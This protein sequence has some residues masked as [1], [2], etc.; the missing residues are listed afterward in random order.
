MKFKTDYYLESPPKATPAK[1]V[2]PKSELRERGLASG[3]GGGTSEHG[4]LWRERSRTACPALTTSSPATPNTHTLRYIH[5]CLPL[6]LPLSSFDPPLTQEC[7]QLSHVPPSLLL[8]LY[9]SLSLTTPSPPFLFCLF[10]G[11]LLI[12][13]SAPPPKNI[14]DSEEVRPTLLIAPLP[15]GQERG[16]VGASGG[17][18]QGIPYI[19]HC[20]LWTSCSFLPL[21]ALYSYSLF[22]LPFSNRCLSH[23]SISCSLLLNFPLVLFLLIYFLYSP[24]SSLFFF[25]LPFL[26]LPFPTFGQPPFLS[27]PPFL[28]LPSPTPILDSLLLIPYSL[29]SLPPSPFFSHISL[30]SHS[31]PPR[32]FAPSPPRRSL[33]PPDAPFAPR[34]PFAPPD[35]P[36]TRA[37]Q[38]PPS[39]PRRFSPPRHSPPRRPRSPPRRPLRPQTPPSPPDG[40]QTDCF[41]P[42]QFRNSRLPPSISSPSLSPPSSPTPSLSPPSFT[43]P[44]LS[45]LLSLLLP[46]HYTLFPSFSF[47]FSPPPSIFSPSLTSLLSLFPP[48]SPISPSLPTAQP[49]PPPPPR[50]F[51]N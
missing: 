30:P 4:S 48:L 21:P 5:V 3:G 27:I 14:G 38:T 34:R 13:S 11:V 26:P 49:Y 16:S 8:S 45:P 12:Q 24:S 42:R 43:C 6:T 31:P 33:R 2:S 15:P 29:S 40:H 18:K 19:T 50:P 41:P 47:C 35:G 1:P 17:N 23:F 9:P 28:S 51:Q 36:Q 25:P 20:E 32:P 44:S 46:S 22:P 10:H 7:L 37:P 39:P